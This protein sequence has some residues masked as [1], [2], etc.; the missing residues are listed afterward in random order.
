MKKKQLLAFMLSDPASNRVE[1][2][3][4]TQY[5]KKSIRS[6][7]SAYKEHLGKRK[8]RCEEK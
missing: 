4:L 7:P 6:A 3:S 1:M 5:L 2:I 8:E